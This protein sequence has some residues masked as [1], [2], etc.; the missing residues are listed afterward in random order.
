M[1]ELIKKYGR[2]EEG[3]VDITALAVLL[4]H[5]HGQQYAVGGDEGG[6][7]PDDPRPHA[8]GLPAIFTCHCHES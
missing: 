1:M 4:S 2:V 3:R 8:H 5:H 6:P 7:Q